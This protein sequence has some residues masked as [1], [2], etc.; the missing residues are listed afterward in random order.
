MD[1]K[2]IQIDAIGTMIGSPI[3]FRI[4]GKDYHTTPPT[5]G[6]LQ[7]MSRELLA[8]DFDEEKLKKDPYKE[9]LRLCIEKTQA[10][11]RFL[12]VVVL[13]SKEDLLNEESI[14]DKANE[15]KW[16]SNVLELVPTVARL[17]T[18]LDCAN[19]TTSI[20]LMR[21]LDLN[22]NTGLTQAVE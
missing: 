19:F 21:T 13:N 20:A 1:E 16:S 7:V 15:I 11:C 22:K 8:M 10:V 18:Q 12:A 2:D 9:S 5:F 14:N 4:G 17:M 3:D 6:K